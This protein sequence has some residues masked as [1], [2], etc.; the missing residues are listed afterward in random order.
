MAEQALYR[1]PYCSPHRYNHV[2]KSRDMAPTRSLLELASTI[3]ARTAAIQD[4][5][6]SGGLPAPTFESGG[7]PMLMLPAANEEDRSALLEA[8]DEMRALVMGPL[9]YTA[10]SAASWV[11]G[12]PWG[13]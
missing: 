4:A 8:L 12:R 6:K 10:L 11:S 2:V 3:Q 7:P 13:A 9:T 5:L 1:A